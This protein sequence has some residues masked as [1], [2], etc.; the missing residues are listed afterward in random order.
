MKQITKQ[1]LD[2]ITKLIF[3]LNCPAPAWENYKQ[4]IASLPDVVEP[5]EDEKK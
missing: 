4:L 5:K 3:E 1:Q 2:G